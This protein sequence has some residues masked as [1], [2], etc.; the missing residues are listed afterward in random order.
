MKIVLKYSFLFLTCLFSVF[1]GANAQEKTEIDSFFNILKDNKLADTT[2]ALVLSKLSYTYL[3]NAPENTLKYAQEAL[4]LSQKISFSKGEGAALSQIGSFYWQVGKYP[5]AMSYYLQALSIEEKIGNKEGIARNLNNL[6]LVYDSQNNLDKA[7]EYYQKSLRID[8]EINNYQAIPF[9]LNNIGVIYYRKKEYGK[10]L[11]S[12]L[13]GLRIAEKN[14]DQSLI[15]VSLNNIGDVYLSVGKYDDAIRFQK[16]AM[17]LE[18]KINDQEGV[19]YSLDALAKSYIAL[20]KLDSAEYYIMQA[21]Q[22]NQKLGITPQLKENYQS[23]KEIAFQRKD[24][25][26]AYWY[27]NAYSTI[28]DSLFSK[29]KNE[30]INQLEQNYELGKKQAEIDVLQNENIIKQQEIEKQNL[31]RIIWVISFGVALAFVF[32]LYFLYYQRN[33]ANTK[34]NNINTQLNKTNR[35]LRDLNATK[36]KL[37]SIISHDLRSPFSTLKSSLELMRMNAFSPEEIEQVSTQLHQ[38]VENISYTLDNLLQW[39]MF[40]MKKGERTHIEK[41]ALNEVIEETVNFYAEVAKNKEITLATNLLPDLYVNV[42]KN[43]MRFVFRNL[44][45]NALKF[46]FP[47]GKI[48]IS[49]HIKGENIEIVVADTG[50]GMTEEQIDK[51]FSPANRSTRGTKG[52]KGTGLGLLLCKEFVENNGGTISV[53]SQQYKGSYFLITMKVV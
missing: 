31:W 38:N 46:T 22:V 24:Y 15:G 3:R 42:D 39:S 40:Q 36:D 28:L 5:R 9:G 45:N 20:G 18:E 23:I 2:R 50:V 14:S 16:Q 29:D 47:Q 43:Q 8:K 34:L 49:S 33:K 27:A 7:L 17:I 11:E 13:E 6:G 48:T 19:A 53:T 10:A 52:E 37:F 4:A 35:E 25:M 32:G 41:V 26:K 21:V 51:L 1:V 30:L 12:Y 44:L